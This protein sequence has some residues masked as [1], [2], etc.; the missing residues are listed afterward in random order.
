MLY[1]LVDFQ[2]MKCIVKICFKCM[3]TYFVTHVVVFF[4]SNRMNVVNFCL[5]L[6]TGTYVNIYI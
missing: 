4:S 6:S 5:M 2:S 1:M 3:H